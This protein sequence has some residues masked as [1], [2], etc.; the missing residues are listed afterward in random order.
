MNALRLPPFVLAAALACVPMG[1]MFDE[2][3]G[4]GPST[5]TG[6]PN[7]RG[8]LIDAGGH[9]AAGSVKLFRLATS[10][11]PDSA[12]LKPP[13][14]IGT[15]AAQ[16]DGKYRFDSLPPAVYALEATDTGSR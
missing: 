8:T 13:V 10:A 12:V 5:E 3:P 9:P 6:N 16:A 7:L 4:E 14:W 11:N 2:P 1:C 15:F